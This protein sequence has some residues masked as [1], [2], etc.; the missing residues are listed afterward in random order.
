MSPTYG[1][2]LVAE[3]SEALRVGEDLERLEA[4]DQGVDAQVELAPSD[5]QRVVDVA[6]DDVALLQ[7]EDLRAAAAAPGLDLPQLL[8]T[9]QQ[10]DALTL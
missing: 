2:F 7:A 9:P 10:E 6:L 8:D 3:A 1:V 5:K 4:G